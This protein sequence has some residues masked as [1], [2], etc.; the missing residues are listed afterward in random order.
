MILLETD[1]PFLAP[2]PHRGARNE[3]A[4][5]R[6]IA[7]KIAELRHMDYEQV[8]KQTSTNSNRLFHT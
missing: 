7:E 6:I 5:L 2:H 3:P 8:I 1:A 4:Y